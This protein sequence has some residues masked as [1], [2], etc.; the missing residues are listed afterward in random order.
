MVISLG[1]LKL[2]LFPREKKLQQHYPKQL[3]QDWTT[4][5]VKGSTALAVGSRH[6]RSF[7]IYFYALSERDFLWVCY[8]LFKFMLLYCCV[9]CKFRDHYISFYAQFCALHSFLKPFEALQAQL[10]PPDDIPQHSHRN[11]KLKSR[12]SYLK[13]NSTPCKLHH[14]NLSNIKFY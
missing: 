3:R 13:C 14:L 2:A 12:T 1:F 9:W 11:R 10:N 8:I 7:Y 5:A 6:K 4:F